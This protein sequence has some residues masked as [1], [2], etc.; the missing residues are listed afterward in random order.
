MRMLAG[1]QHHLRR[2]D[3]RNRHGGFLLIDHAIR[4]EMEAA[5]LYAYAQASG[6]RIVCLAHL[7]N[8]TGKKCSRLRE[9][10]RRRRSPS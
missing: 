10:R 2:A 1:R 3:R 8:D 6:A 7:S 9:G 5:A 4:D